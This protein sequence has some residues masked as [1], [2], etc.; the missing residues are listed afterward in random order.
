MFL[1]A[2]AKHRYGKNID[3]AKFQTF[4][5][6]VSVFISSRSSVYW[7]L[8]GPTTRERHR[9]WDMD[10]TF[11]EMV[12][13]SAWVLQ[14]AHRGMYFLGYRQMS[15]K[16]TKFEGPTYPSCGARWSLVC[17]G[18]PNV[19][20]GDKT[21]YSGGE[22]SSITWVAGEIETGC[23]KLSISLINMTSL[24]SWRLMHTVYHYSFSQPIAK[25][26]Q[27]YRKYF[28]NCCIP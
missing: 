27:F 4:L 24:I 1:V 8:L 22:C 15:V 10:T 21:M 12:Y 5:A 17:T 28:S 20:E 6:S 3:V 19:K 18:G 25:L 23:G 7:T 16:L 2:E 26:S 11:H 14:Y 13:K 9:L